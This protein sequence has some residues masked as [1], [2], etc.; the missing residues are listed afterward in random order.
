M[1][2]IY[3][4]ILNRDSSNLISASWDK[5][6]R[7]WPLE[8]KEK[9][10]TLHGHTDA[11]RTLVI[12]P[13]SS[14]IISGSA[15]NSIRIW[16]MRTKKQLSILWG[17]KGT[18]Y[19][20]L[21][22][23]DSTRIISG[24]GD[25][26][27]IV[28]DIGTKTQLKTFDDHTNAVWTI[29]F[30]PD[31]TKIVS[32]GADKTIRIWDFENKKVL[33]VLTGHTGT[34]YSLA[35]TSDSRKIISGGWDKFI[36]IWDIQTKQLIDKLESNTGTV[37]S[38]V[39][40]SDSKKIIT[41]N[42][43]KTIRI[44]DL[45]TKKHSIMWEGEA[46][47]RSM[48]I[49]S[50]GTRIVTGSGDNLIRIWDLETRKLIYKLKGHTGAVRS[51]ALT[52]DSNKVISGSYDNSIRVW[53]LET[54]NQIGHLEGQ[55]AFYSLLLTPDS[56]RIISGSYEKTI[57]IWEIDTKIQGHLE[58]HTNV[59]R[60]IAF[61]LDSKQIFSGS[62]DNS[63]RIWDTETGKQTGLLEGHSDTVYCL[64]VCGNSLIS[65]GYDGTIRFWDLE[66]QQQ[67]DKYVEHK[68]N[69][70]VLCLAIMAN[71][72][73]LISGGSDSIIRIWDLINKEQKEILEGHS[74]A[75]RVLIVSPNGEKLVSGSADK[76]IIVWNLKNMKEEA[77]LK[78]HNGTVRSIVVNPNSKKIISGSYDNTIRI[79]D[80]A[81]KICVYKIES[82]VF[83]QPKPFIT[84]ENERVLGVLGH[85]VYDFNNEI[86]LF[87]VV[88]YETLSEIIYCDKRK[89]F[90]CMNKN[91]ILSVKS[92]QNVMAFGS[93]FSLIQQ[94]FK[95]NNEN[96]DDYLKRFPI[97]LP[98][99]YNFLH[100]IAIFD[101]KKPFHFEKFEKIQVPIK[102]FL[103]VDF[104]NQ[105]CIDIAI[106]L[107]LKSLLKTYMELLINSLKDPSTSFYDKMRIFAS[108]HN[109]NKNVFHISNH[110]LSIF[111]KD[112]TILSH[113]LEL[114]YVNLD[115]ACFYNNMSSDELDSP[116]FLV[117]ENVSDLLK[118]EALQNVL[119]PQ[120]N[121]LFN[122]V[123]NRKQKQA[124]VKCK[125][126]LLK[127][128]TE[129]NEINQEVHKK[130]MNFDP[131]N[132]LYSNKI[133]QMLIKYKWETYAKR[134]LLQ[135]FI[136][137][138]IIFLIYLANNI[139]ILPIRS[140]NL[141]QEF[142]TNYDIIALVL[143]ICIITYF[144]FYG[145][146]E[147]LQLKRSGLSTYFA[148]PWNWCDVLLIPLVLAG[149]IL[150]IYELFLLNSSMDSEKIIYSITLLIFW[151]RVL[152]YSRAFE[153]T[154]FMIRLVIQ[155]IL[156]M[157]N[158]LFLIIL[159]TLA[160][161]SSGYMLQK[162]FDM[163]QWDSFTLFYRLM[164]GD[165]SQY[166]SRFNEGE[167]MTLLW[168]LMILFT[169]L[170]TVIMLNLLISIIGETFA[171]VRAAESSMKFYE[172][173]SI[174]TEIDSA[175]SSFTI[176][177]L[178]EE[179][180]I[181]N[182]LICLYNENSQ[183]MHEES[184]PNLFIEQTR[185]IE[186]EVMKISDEMGNFNKE[187]KDFKKHVY[188]N[189]NEIKMLLVN[190]RMKIQDNEV[191]EGMMKSFK[192][193]IID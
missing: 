57:R 44:W 34:V 130:I 45:G 169:L 22:T 69:G 141:N 142:G 87:N 73:I 155:V 82:N 147:L 121:F 80:I 92:F 160:F 50:D 47:V 56:K 140:E 148:N 35:I 40:T 112:T 114:S 30:T 76:S 149:A 191:F 66:K 42:W 46:V 166:D 151:S 171:K 109:E 137:F 129:I 95:E 86:P 54:G 186:K 144:S 37:Y 88:E 126:V 133:F 4:I 172:L 188:E 113:F 85:V 9:I 178:R 117:I 39:I 51:L 79:W 128:F 24:S 89:S 15:D 105:T 193:K 94:I 65:G 18:V 53:E 20:L 5:S 84:M 68:D 134:Y 3:C 163:S 170:L 70:A 43:D 175:M 152:S 75:I 131:E 138:L 146:H 180:K 162:G 122:L 183:L 7:I 8:L 97:L 90:I 190:E 33:G 59:I 164:L 12:S 108:D 23:G 100:I 106:N 83:L 154:G 127:G 182:Y 60:S 177:R 67:E 55:G 1:S 10:D 157:R 192:K 116:I 19:C 36:C 159:F 124:D 187:M 38:L 185:K 135:Q 107:N 176:N 58:G 72:R 16:D 184:K 6:I 158:F 173:Y 150:D 174:I 98:F 119:D 61:S 32:A 153:G 102:Y 17:H 29:I 165:Y 52:P 41:G 63:I 13:D 123:S 49:T 64:L 168:I 11:V 77:K 21:I 120:K 167:S 179:K 111:E 115:P 96:I 136:S 104:Q 99:Y 156:D 110:L 161:S 143:E 74:D 14:K 71:N 145:F 103:Q 28:W 189:I 132:Q 101:N 139:Y 181:G 2:T 25:K 78:G 93:N 125:V 27:I 48:A 91:D 81:S 26:S 118:K 31:A 62:A